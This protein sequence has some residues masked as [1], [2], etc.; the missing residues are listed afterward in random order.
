MHQ[1]PAENSSTAAPAPSCPLICGP[2]ALVRWAIP[3]FPHAV[4]GAILVVSALVLAAVTNAVS[5]LGIGWLPSADGRVGIPRAYESR[6]PQITV[7]EAFRIYQSGNPLFVDSRDEKDFEDDRIPGAVNIPQRRWAEVWP[8]W[9]SKLPR[10]RQLLLYCY[11][12]HCGLSTRQAK[13]LIVEGYE[14]FLIVDHGW[15][16]W[17]AAGYPTELHPQG[18]AD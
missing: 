7:D 15:D 9:Q 16:G 8:E 4:R 6:L 11:G 13:R 3:R 12:G 14:D 2:A 17:I 18:K 1:P 10:D 5:P